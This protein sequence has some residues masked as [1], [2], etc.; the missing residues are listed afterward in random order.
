MPII[1][2]LALAGFVIW[3]YALVDAVQVPEDSMYR[4]GNKLIWVLVILL[5][6]AV[7]ALIYL[8][9]GRPAQVAGRRRPGIHDDTL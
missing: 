7:G 1:A 2:M 6:H 9:V 3:V 5:G 8:A 4:A